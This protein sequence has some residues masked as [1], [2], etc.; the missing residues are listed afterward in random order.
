MDN[1]VVVISTSILHNLRMSLALKTRGFVVRNS[2]KNISQKL[3]F[4]ELIPHTSSFGRF[5]SSLYEYLAIIKYILFG[6][7]D[8]KTIIS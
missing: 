7:I 4:S 6:Y 3:I 2:T 1:E 5:N 8:F